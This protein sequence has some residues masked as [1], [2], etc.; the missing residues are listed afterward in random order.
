MSAQAPGPAP[1]GTDW[2]A[3]LQALAELLAEQR[4]VLEQQRNDALEDVTGRVERA[5]A[6]LAQPDGGFPDL[7]SWFEQAT[8]AE[9]QQVAQL[10]DR[11]QSDNRVSGEMLR[12]AMQRLALVRAASADVNASGTYG[13]GNAA[14]PAGSR[15]SRR[16]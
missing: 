2:L 14:L 9:R 10:L 11:A 4:R 15:L 12:L 5:Y 7:T 8:P 6:A 3:T 13:P 1:A 16:A